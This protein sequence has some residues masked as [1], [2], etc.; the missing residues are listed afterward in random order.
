MRERRPDIANYM[1]NYNKYYGI[2]DSNIPEEIS[3][4]SNMIVHCRCPHDHDFSRI[5]SKMNRRSVDKY[6]IICCPTC[7]DE[8]LQYRAGSISIFDFAMEHEKKRAP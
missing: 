3:I 8:G 2:I 4:S 7:L 1:D 6:G 5:A